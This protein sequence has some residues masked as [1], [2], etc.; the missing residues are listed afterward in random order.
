MKWTKNVDEKDRETDRQTDRQTKKH[1]EIDK[2]RDRETDMQIDRQAGR[3]IKQAD[4]T[5]LLMKML[6]YLPHRR[7]YLQ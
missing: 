2:E 5:G 3:Q 4:W 1:K 6:P 7:T